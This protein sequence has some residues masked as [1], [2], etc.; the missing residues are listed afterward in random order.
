MKASGE[1]LQNFCVVSLL[2]F[3]HCFD[4]D[5][6]DDEMMSIIKVVRQRKKEGRERRESG[7]DR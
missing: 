6:K 5:K 3:S 4:T 7:K 2:R 1:N